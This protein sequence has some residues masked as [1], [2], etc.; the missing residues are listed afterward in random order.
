MLGID[1]KV[2]SAF[3][4]MDERN[5]A[6]IYRLLSL[7]FDQKVLYYTKK[8][9]V[10]G[11]SKWT[12]RKKIGII[13]DVITGHSSRPLRLLTK[14]SLLFTFIIFLR[15]LYV[16]INVYILKKPPTVLEIILN[17]IFTSTAV[18]MLILSAM[19]DYIWRILDETRKRPQYE[20]SKISGNIQ[21][22]KNAG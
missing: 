12:T 14:L 3:N 8:E 16:F 22:E 17:S 21:K 13:I 11:K 1:K 18:M 15:W 5:T 9:R 2:L 10:A 20:I 19:G 7:G 4:K 6:F